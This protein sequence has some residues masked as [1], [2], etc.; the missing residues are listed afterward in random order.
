MPEKGYSVQELMRMRSSL[1]S[2][3][4]SKANVVNAKVGYV[5][6]KEV[7]HKVD[8]LL[9]KKATLI[10]KG[11]FLD[12]LQPYLVPELVIGVPDRGK[13]FATTLAYETDLP[14]G[15]SKRDEIKSG[16]DQGFQANYNEKKDTLVINGISSFTNPGVLYNHKIRGLKPGS[17]VLVA[18]DFS[19]TGN[20]TE[21]YNRAF[22]QLGITAIFVYIV[23]KD[24]TNSEPPQQGY[25][26]NKEKGAPVF[27]VVRLTD[28]VDGKVKV[29]SEDIS[30]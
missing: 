3:I 4:E 15:V 23:S 29:T 28:I 14:I 25:R 6:I 24:F 13:E 11:L 19:A 20:V 9:L 27:T 30:V 18:D 21:H 16:Q 2:Y 1:A 7:N 17:T 5:E 26:K 22:E 8:T 10:T 12:R